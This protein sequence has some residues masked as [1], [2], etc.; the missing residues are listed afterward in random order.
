MLSLISKL[1]IVS[2]ALLVTAISTGAH[3]QS[4]TLDPLALPGT[5]IKP[6]FV[7]AVT[8]TVNA[9]R[10]KELCRNYTVAADGSIQM[11][12]M[13]Q[14]LD[15]VQVA[16]LTTTEAAVKITDM[17]KKYILEPVVDV[18]I[19]H[20]PRIEVFVDGA[21]FRLGEVVLPTNSRL[22]DALAISGYLPN[23]D[24]SHIEI[25]RRNVG[26][27]PGHLIVNFKRFLNPTGNTVDVADDPLLEPNDHITVPSFTQTE[28]A[29]PTVAMLGEVV[30]PGN[31]PYHSGM[32]V[33]DALSA[34]GGLTSAADP[35]DLILRRLED[36]KVFILN[37]LKAEQGDPVNDLT[38]KPE[39]T[40][41]ANT[42][43]TGLK[44]SVMG[45][46]AFPHTF[47]Y[48]GP[49]TLTDAIKNAGGLKPNADSGKILLL[50]G[51]LND[52]TTAR[53]VPINLRDVASGAL[54]DPIIHSGDL[55]QVPVRRSTG[56][57]FLGIG[58]L[59][60]RLLRF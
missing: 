18:S 41:F 35:T 50:Q 28:L 6:H 32:R 48:T 47:P 38:L 40:L 36:N 42:K 30:R 52:P 2:I 19:A 8:V 25:F 34:A 27:G 58:A 45:A 15:R 59:L 9:F 24:L 17:L 10:E 49:V 55:I 56:F 1:K 16:G 26:G 5:L 3:A 12:I 37:A 43:D 44:Y 13:K 54:P 51:F 22:S 33:S 60:L 14:P 57:P 21:V 53:T 7:L 31:I 23:A 29:A 4:D 46:V 39:D 11:Y 20:I